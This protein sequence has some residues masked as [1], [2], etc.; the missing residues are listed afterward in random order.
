M[1]NGTTIGG[2]VAD[3]SGGTV[4]NCGFYGVVEGW[5]SVGGVVGSG[6]AVNCWY[7][8]TGMDEGYSRSVCSGTATKCYT[9]VNAEQSGV[10]VV[11][12]EQFKGT[13]EAESLVSLLNKN[14]P[15]NC[16]NWAQGTDY[17]VF[18]TGGTEQK[19]KTIRLIPL[20]PDCEFVASV[21]GEGVTYDV[22]KNIYTIG[23]D[24]SVVKLTRSDGKPELWVTT[25]E[26]G[27][28]ASAVSSSED[29]PISGTK[30][31]LYY[32]TKDDFD[33]I[34]VWNSALNG[35]TATI[36]DADTLKALA[37]MVNSGK[38]SMTGKTITLGA[39]INLENAA[40]TSIGTGTNPF[41]GTFNGRMVV[42]TTRFPA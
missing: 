30:T 7:Y 37:R 38:D 28:E 20:F 17:P 40:W 36:K 42:L 2:I 22:A 11:T 23:A 26:D 19:D 10:T 5:R 4:Q 25:K 29:F 16:M 34:A 33:T 39:N 35:N 3:N 27:T 32:G 12:A 8:Y 18:A 1:P 21:E 14:V 15:D 9:N 6:N 24:T 31:T 41:K 13:G